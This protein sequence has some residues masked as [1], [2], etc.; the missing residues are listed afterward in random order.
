M[1]IGFQGDSGLATDH[2]KKERVVIS[3][4]NST[5]RT[6]LRLAALLAP[7]WAVYIPAL[8]LGIFGFYL[9]PVFFDVNERIYLL[10]GSFALGSVSTAALLINTLVLTKSKISFPPLKAMQVPIVDV[11]RLCWHW[12]DYEKEIYLRF[13]VGSDHVDIHHSRL[14]VRKLLNLRAALRKWSPKCRWE[15]EPEDLEDLT[16]LRERFYKPK[17]RLHTTGPESKSDFLEIPYNPHEQFDKFKQ[18]LSENEKYFWY[19]WVAGLLLAYLMRI[20]DIVWGFIADA[21]H[22]ERFVDVPV[23]VRTIDALESFVLGLLLNGLGSA[24]EVY[25]SVATNPFFICLCLG[26]MWIS[27]IALGMFVFQPNGIR[28]KS[29]CLQLFF[30]W[31]K[32]PL[33]RRSYRWEDMLAFELD[34]FGDVANPEKW[35]MQ[36]RMQD[37][38][39][40]NLN[41]ESIKGHVSRETLLRTIT[42]M[43]PNAVQDPALIRALM[44]PQRESYTELWLQSLTTPP[45]R[46]RLTPLTD[47]V[48]LKSGRYVIERQL[49]TGGQGVAYIA[50]DCGPYL[51]NECERSDSNEKE[52]LRGKSGSTVVL[53]EFVLPVYTS[54]NVRK[55]ALERFENEARILEE[56]NHPQ[57]VKL[58]DFFLEDHR[59]YL[60]LEHIDGLSLRQIVQKC[61]PL[62]LD[63]IIALSLQMCDVLHYLHALTPSVVHR[64]FTPDN[65]ILDASGRLVLIDFNVAQ[66]KQWTTTSTVVGKHAYLPAEQFRGKP[67]PQS[68]LYAMGATLFYLFSGRDPEPITSSHPSDFDANVIPQFDEIVSKLTH[69]EPEQRYQSAIEV[70]E[71]LAALQGTEVKL[72]DNVISILKLD[73]A[74]SDVIDLQSVEPM[75]EVRRFKNRDWKSRSSHG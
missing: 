67:V 65:L 71:A 46:N 5:M 64:D 36:I 47:G 73:V 10:L 56:L 12:D 9:V 55:Q 22:V 25:V 13:W 54:R 32:I 27:T 58:T 62:S 69:T 40:V 6:A 19:C 34:Q 1:D 21:R 16:A 42:E 18:S 50:R 49:A 11:D 51:Q 75:P 8:F 15:A 17:R 70:R 66:Q 7:L 37:K 20:P 61:G 53:K 39:T 35:R 59:A 29:D 28:L 43:A 52:L 23:F 57:I 24:S 2:V 74:G 41:I 3:T 33:F 48:K 31:K 38:T 45:N 30:R 14:S 72:P 44:P 26:V 63:D 4:H 68:D 60:V